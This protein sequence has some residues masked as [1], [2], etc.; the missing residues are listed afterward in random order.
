[1]ATLFE[2]ITKDKK[3][4]AEYLLKCCDNPISDLNQD[5]CDFCAISDTEQECNECHC[6]D[7]I[8]KWLDSEVN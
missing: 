4:L 5:M 1:M 2:Y 8:V 7:A 6:I 3:S